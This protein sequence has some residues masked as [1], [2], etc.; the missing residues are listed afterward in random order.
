M[1][2]SP[3]RRQAGL[4]DSRS[5]PRS[6]TTCWCWRWIPQRPP[7]ASVWSLA[8]GPSGLRQPDW[9]ELPEKFCSPQSTPC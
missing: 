7:R 3:A 6:L 4:P 9:R 8:T 5:W 2:R 1:S